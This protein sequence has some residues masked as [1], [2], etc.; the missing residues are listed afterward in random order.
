MASIRVKC[1]S[2]ATLHSIFDAPDVDVDKKYQL[3][4]W[5]MRPIPAEMLLYARQDT[6][7]L[8]YVYDRM[9]NELVE[10][11]RRSSAKVMGGSAGSVG[12]AHEIPIKLK[13]VWER[14]RAIALKV[15]EKPGTRD[16]R[17]VVCV[18]VCVCV[19]V[20]VVC[21]CVCVCAC[22]CFLGWGQ[23]I[24]ACAMC[25]GCVMGNDSGA[26]S[27]PRRAMQTQ[28]LVIERSAVAGAQ[29]CAQVAGCCCAHD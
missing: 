9:R 20:C 2:S 26:R 24:G 7:Y 3:A 27:V 6:H 1:F 14:S 17:P 19:C 12:G 18:Y 11:S 15:Y 10:Q 13:Y 25:V 4:D 29:G 28:W 8:L 16:A 21:V 22:V 23:S 5:R